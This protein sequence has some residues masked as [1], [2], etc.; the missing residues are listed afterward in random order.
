MALNLFLTYL[1]YSCL[2][3]SGEKVIKRLTVQNISKEPLDVSFLQQIPIRM[4]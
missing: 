2:L 4:S 1:T 3:F